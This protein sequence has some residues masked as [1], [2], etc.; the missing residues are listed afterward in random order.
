MGFGPDDDKQGQLL[1][2]LLTIESDALVLEADPRHAEL[3]IAQL[4]LAK[5]STVVTPSVKHEY[6]EL[7]ESPF[8]QGAA[9]TQYRGISARARFLSEDRYDISFPAKEL[10][11]GMSAPRVVHVTMAKRLGRYLKGKPRICRVFRVQAFPKEL[12]MYVDSDHIGDIVTRQG[13]TGYIAYA[14]KLAVKGGSGTHTTPALSTGEDEY[15]SIVRGG[16]E[17]LG[18]K[19]M[20]EDLGVQLSVH[21]Y[22]DSSAA[23]GLSNRLG[24]SRIRH[25]AARLLWIQH[26]L[27]KKLLTMHKVLGTENPSDMCTKHMTKAS[28]DKYMPMCNMEPRAGRAPHAPALQSTVEEISAR[29]ILFNSLLRR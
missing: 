13:T 21:I 29:S 10:C 17:G 20:S 25:L 28:L 27:K 2:R 14:G 9:I 7:T 24:L 23:K 1:N 22:T 26:Y 11:K 6:E 19:S 18:L 5:A 12:N 4:G 3:L 15:Y 16:S 8:L